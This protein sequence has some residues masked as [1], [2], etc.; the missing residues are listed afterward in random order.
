MWP[1]SRLVTAER[2]GYF[3]ICPSLRPNLGEYEVYQL[4]PDQR[5]G[6]CDKNIGDRKMN[7]R[8]KKLF[9]PFFCHQFFCLLCF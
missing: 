8:M 4:A 1:R 9:A 7:R 2:D 5:W 6:G 3:A